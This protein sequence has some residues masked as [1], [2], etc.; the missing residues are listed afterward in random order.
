MS[1]TILREISKNIQN[2]IYYT[3]IADE[4]TDSSNKEQFV[5]CLCRVDHDLVAHEEL[6]EL[7][8]VDNITSETLLKDVL[9]RMGLS[10]QNCRGQCYDSANNMVGSKSGV[11]TQ[12]QKKEPRAILT[13]CYGHSLQLAVGDMVREVRNL[14]DALDTTS[15]ISKL[16]KYSSK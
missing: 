4:V 9:L 7:Y 2:S 5:V 12:I 1:L 10:V 11:A 14:R 6:V 13:H 8:A 16:L 3:I 15:E